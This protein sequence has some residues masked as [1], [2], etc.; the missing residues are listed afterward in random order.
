MDANISVISD[1]CFFHYTETKT[2]E[3]E[4]TNYKLPDDVFKRIKA[5][6]FGSAS[7]GVP[8]LQVTDSSGSVTGVAK[9][10]STGKIQLVTAMTGAI[11]ITG[12]VPI[13]TK[14]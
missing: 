1:C 7:I 3:D 4:F 5:T 13:Y 6:T 8:V 10:M 11:Y 14:I 12:C 2:A 9:I